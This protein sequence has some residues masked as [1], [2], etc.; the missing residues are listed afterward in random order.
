MIRQDRKQGS[1]LGGRTSS[2]WYYRPCHLSPQCYILTKRPLAA[3]LETLFPHRHPSCCSRSFMDVW[4]L[5]SIPGDGDGIQQVEGQL[6]VLGCWVYVA[7][8]QLVLGLHRVS[9]SNLAGKTLVLT[10]I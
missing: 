2:K 1:M 6:P 9:A 5:C 3:Q 4:G 7:P 10:I 8:D